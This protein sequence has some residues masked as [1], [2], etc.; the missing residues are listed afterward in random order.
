MPE[1]Q[2]S[3]LKGEIKN[4]KARLA[5]IEHWQKILEISFLKSLES[6]KTR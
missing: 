5:A 1:E 6:R 4:L 2:I 3:S